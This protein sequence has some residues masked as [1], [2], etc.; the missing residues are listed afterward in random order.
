VSRAV[1]TLLVVALL[2][3][4][5]TNDDK[6]SQPSNRLPD[7]SLSSLTGGADVDLGQLRG[8]V[9]VNLWAQWCTPCRRELPI[10]ES[11]FQRH[12]DQVSVLGIDWQ[13]VQT[14][15]ARK[16]AEDSGVSY[17]LVVDSEPEIRGKV[18]PRLVLLDADGTIA[19]SEY[20]EIKSL[21]QL[22]QLVEKHLGVAL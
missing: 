21:H 4:G 18:L 7:V 17:P 10:Y 15:R 6:P 20:V 12:G 16:L 11:F 1:L 2:A 13:D 19:Y 3:T 14:D 5:C 9:V 22:E 8:P